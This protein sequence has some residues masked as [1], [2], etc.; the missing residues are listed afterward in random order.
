LPGPDDP[1]S[2]LTCLQSAAS[3]GS[4]D[5]WRHLHSFSVAEPRRSKWWSIDAQGVSNQLSS[6]HGLGLDW[7]LA[8]AIPVTGAR[9]LYT[10]RYLLVTRKTNTPVAAMEERDLIRSTTDGVIV[11]HV[12]FGLS[13]RHMLC[14][15]SP[16][17]WEPRRNTSV[18]WLA[19]CERNFEKAALTDWSARF[20]TQNVR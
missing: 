13:S 8:A 20:N 5:P 11:N 12:G 4:H 14:Q 16:F 15:Y 9:R 3:V 17:I 1:K 7:I 2:P 18:T 10:R 19:D 6:K